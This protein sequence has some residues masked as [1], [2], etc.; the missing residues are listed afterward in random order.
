LK[1]SKKLQLRYMEW[2]K[3]IKAEYGSM[4]NY[5][6]SHRLQWGKPDKLSI[7]SSR[8]LVESSVNGIENGSAV[9]DATA[10]TSSG[11]GVPPVPSLP[12]IPLNAPAYF[13]ADTP[14]ELI[15]IITNDWPYSVP[16]DIEH[17]LIWT[18]LPMTPVDLPPSIAPRIAQD[19]LWGFTGTTSPPPSP[20]LLPSC[21]PALAEWGVTLD[22][23]IVSPKGTEEE[24]RLVKEAGSEIDTFIRRRWN[25]EDW[26][27]AWFVNPPRLQ[28]VPG[29]A[30]IHVF[31]RYKK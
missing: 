20:S 14:P 26:E 8:L 4:V 9:S 29:L 23:M 19:G 28:S 31:A 5:L 25:E 16:S 15:S 1:R 7:L 10:Q 30:H 17:S 13:T 27:T 18:R 22:K 11:E 12:S 3:G 6:L 2:A 21:L 24:E